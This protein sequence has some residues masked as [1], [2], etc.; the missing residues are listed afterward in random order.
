MNP[1]VHHLAL[2]TFGPRRVLYGSDNPVFYLRGRRQYE[3][4]RY[5]NRTSYPFFFNQQREAPEIEAG[6]T[7]YMYEELLAIRQACQRLGWGAD[8]VA[9]IFGGNALRLIDSICGH[10]RA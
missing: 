8:E 2:K 9:A 6:Y 5:V 3:G 1:E 7:L 10:S 4:T